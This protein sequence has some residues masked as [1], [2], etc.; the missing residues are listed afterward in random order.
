M[1]TEME[2]EMKGRMQDYKTGSRVPALTLIVIRR[3]V[4][5]KTRKNFLFPISIR[6]WLIAA[7]HIGYFNS[8]ERIVEGPMSSAAFYPPTRAAI[9][10]AR[11]ALASGT[12]MPTRKARDASQ[13]HAIDKG[14]K[15]A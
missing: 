9:K 13:Q 4:L 8:E 12:S 5:V 6:A 2:R 11:L 10:R 3:K 7:P 14:G 15:R 1:R